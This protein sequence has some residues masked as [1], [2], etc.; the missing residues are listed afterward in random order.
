VSLRVFVIDDEACIRDTFKMYLEDQGHEVLTS[1]RPSG[2]AVYQGHDCQNDSPCGHA[3]FIDYFMPGMNGLEF[4]EMMQ[5][6]GCKGM[7][8]NKIIMSGDSTA[9]D[10]ERAEEL[11]CM[12]VQKPVSFHTLDKIIDTVQ[13]SVNSD[14]KLADLPI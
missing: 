3:L 11:G 8:Q 2:C 4:I 6:A 7:M 13:A 1:D 10:Q 14:E 9:I 5:K 12:I